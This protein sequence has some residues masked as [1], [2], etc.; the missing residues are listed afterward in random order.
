LVLVSYARA[1]QKLKKA[2]ETSD[3]N[4]N[5]ESECHSAKRR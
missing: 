3:I 5:S 4:T 2:E 1:R